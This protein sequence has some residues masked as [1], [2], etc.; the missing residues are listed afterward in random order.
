MR[1]LCIKHKIL[2]VFISFLIGTLSVF[3]REDK[4]SVCFF[5][6]DNPPFELYK[7]C[8][9]LVVDPR[10]KHVYKK[11]KAKLIAYISIGE[12]SKNSEDYKSIKKSWIIGENKNWNSVILDITNPEYQKF[13][14]NKINKYKNF[15][16]FFFDTVDSYQTVLKDK[17]KKSKYESSLIN[18]IKSVK[19]IYPSKKILLNRGFEIF[20]SVKSYIDGIVVESLFYGLDLKNNGY[21]EITEEERNWL[22][23]ILKKMKNEGVNVIVIDYLPPKE[24]KKAFEISKKIKRLGFIPYITNKEI[25][26]IGTSFFQIKPRRALILYDKRACPILME[27]GAHYM[28]QL[29][30]EYYGYIPYLREI[31]IELPPLDEPLVDKFG[32]IVVWLGVNQVMNPKKFHNWVVKRIEGGNRI[33]FIDNFGFPLTDEYLKPLGIKSETNRGDGGNYKIVYKDRNIGFESEPF[34]NFEGIAIYP[35]G[36]N[37]KPLFILENN[38]RQKTVPIALTDW[39]GYALY[40]AATFTRFN[41]TKWVV[42]PL[43]FFK[44]AFNIT[45]YPMPDTTTLSGNRI[46]YIHI[47]GNG[48]IQPLEYNSKKF[49]S[50]SIR[51]E[52]I[53]KYKLPHSISIIEG[54]IAPWGAY[55]KLPH[56][57]LEKI[58]RSIFS[59]PNVEPA[60][61][62]FSHPFKWKAVL[63]SKTIKKGYSLQIKGYYKFDLKREI[64]GSLNYISTRLTPPN[65]KAKLMFWTGDCNP[66][67]KAL[68]I[69]YEN[70]ILNI[71]GGDTGISY[72]EPYLSLVAPMGVD[73]NGYFQVYASFQ[74]ENYYTNEWKGPYYAYRNVIQAFKLTDKKWRFKPINIYYHFYIA[75]KYASKKSL[76]DVYEW[77]IKQEITP[78]YTSD[79]I[80]NVLS[81]RKS[82]VAYDG[83]GW[84]IRTDGNLASLKINGK[85]FVD[86]EKSKGI[87]GYRYL[88]D[89]NMTYIHLDRSGDYYLVL[90]YKTDKDKNFSYIYSFNGFIE[91]IEKEDRKLIYWLKSYVPAEIKFAEVKYCNINIIDRKDYK[92]S[93]GKNFKIYRFKKGGDI[94][95]E[96][97][98]KQ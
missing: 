38:K 6:H 87:G 86:I 97:L 71:N 57:K 25:N 47:D 9:W 45:N 63:T 56:K 88:K 83:N 84:V 54:E 40:G 17:S 96:I 59:L 3:G 50:E 13:L 28:A 15:D 43:Y 78:I 4:P 48:F 92:V 16:G 2:F 10:N 51:D 32:A 11:D 79:Y 91:K 62:S 65:K 93:N 90:S 30:L 34:R 27:C 67:W 20:D 76:K 61:H 66:P 14:L 41:T 7:A 23:P 72:R 46:L 53:K 64:L 77:A 8:D 36:K 81:Y 37:S 68:K 29:I 24:R 33:L 21:R 75:S 82:V 42:N 73:K 19:D 94:K 1:H 70:G 22:L 31:N 18:F 49:S 12:V 39:G 58:A 95:V 26:T 52:F 98:C 5:Y 74:N 60:S 89:K 85:V 80:R 35:T 69:C 55:P 44:K